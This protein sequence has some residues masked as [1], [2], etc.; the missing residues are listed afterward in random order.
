MT[1]SKSVVVSYIKPDSNDITD[2]SYKFNKADQWH[3]V[4]Q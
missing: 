2:I 3:S 4:V 1:Y